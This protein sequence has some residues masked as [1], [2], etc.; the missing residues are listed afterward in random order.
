VSINT[1]NDKV[2]VYQGLDGDW[3]WRRVDTTNGKI[4][5]QSSEGYTN[6]SYAMEAA[7]AY[8]P[9]VAVELE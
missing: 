8:N 3:W 9:G 5:S 2:E 4:V 7:A 6:Q 1:E